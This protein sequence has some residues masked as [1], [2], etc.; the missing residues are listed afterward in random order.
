M[1]FHDILAAITAEADTQIAALKTQH[2]RT[3]AD[4]QANA[5]RELERMSEDL[6]ARHAQKSIQ[7]TRKA[8]QESEQIRRNAVL[9]HKRSLLDAVYESI[10]D[11]LS[12]ESD[13]ALTPLFSALLARQSGGEILPAKKHKALL[14]KLTHGKKGFVI[15]ETIDAKGGF[16]CI[17]PTREED[18]RIESLVQDVLRP[19]TE[20]S[21][22]EHL[23]PSA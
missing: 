13:D 4:A 5:N 8:K 9:Q 3:V 2:E 23:F 1:A 11:K 20:L 6:R 21:A 18:C 7:V 12:K 19:R 14:E 16:L 15:G 10:V 22:A 17:S